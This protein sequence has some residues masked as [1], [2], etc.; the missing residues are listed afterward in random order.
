MKSL[1][2]ILGVDPLATKD[3]IKKAYK[4]KIRTKHPDVGGDAEEFKQIVKAYM[5]LY[6]DEARY[7]YNNGGQQE[8]PN[9]RKAF[10][11][12]K[13]AKS[14][15]INIAF[16]VIDNIGENVS[17]KNLKNAILSK[18]AELETEINNRI[19]NTKTMWKALKKKYISVKDKLNSLEQDNNFLIEILNL[20]LKHI[21]IQELLPI[22]QEYKKLI[23]DKS[24]IRKASEL[25]NNTK[26]DLQEMVE[27]NPYNDWDNSM[28]SFGFSPTST[29]FR[30]SAGPF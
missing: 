12:N 30:Y 2:D 23:R 4:K 11:I 26:D 17:K 10:D 14:F 27:V 24:V 9:E 18:L 16:A 6:D 15:A 8:T 7:K 13:A 22:R 21:E 5:I 29:T 20:K 19:S 1:Y 28:S 3:E 25:I